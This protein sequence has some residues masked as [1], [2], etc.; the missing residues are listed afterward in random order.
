MATKYT[1]RRIFLVNAD[2]RDVI[3]ELLTADLGPNTFSVPMYDDQKKITHYGCSCQLTDWQLALIKRSVT[4]K[5][6][7]T[8]HTKNISGVLLDTGLDIRNDK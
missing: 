3:N 2:Q 4:E 5:S 1:N 6:L 7:G 8:E